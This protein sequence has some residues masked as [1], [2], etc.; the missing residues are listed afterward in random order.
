MQPKHRPFATAVGRLARGESEPM[1]VLGQHRAT[2]SA[3]FPDEMLT[4]ADRGSGLDPGNSEDD[5]ELRDLVVDIRGSADTDLVAASH[6][7]VTV[8][9]VDPEETADQHSLRLQS[10]Q[11]RLGAAVRFLPWGT[12]ESLTPT[13]R[14]HFVV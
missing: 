13:D 7:A 3:P 6:D 11:L 4:P 1:D 2:Q 12:W 5:D 9:E 14:P 10:L 8:L